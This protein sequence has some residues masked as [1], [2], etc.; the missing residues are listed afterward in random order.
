MR[1]SVKEPS[2]MILS[3]RKYFKNGNVCRKVPKQGRAKRDGVINPQC[4]NLNEL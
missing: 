2:S 3:Q 1:I 4:Y